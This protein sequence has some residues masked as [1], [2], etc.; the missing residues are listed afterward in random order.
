MTECKLCRSVDTMF[1]WPVSFGDWEY[2]FYLCDDCMHELLEFMKGVQER[3]KPLGTKPIKWEEGT[4]KIKEKKCPY[5]GAIPIL[6][7]A[8]RE[9]Y[10][11]PTCFRKFDRFGK[12]VPQ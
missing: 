6:I 4:S 8:P 12:E 10:G 9:I 11:C 1:W 7:D 3:E 5:C 2:H